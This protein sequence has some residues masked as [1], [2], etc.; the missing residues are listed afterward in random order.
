MEHEV[1]SRSNYPWILKLS[2]ACLLPMLLQLTEANAYAGDSYRDFLVDHGYLKDYEL[3]RQDNQVYECYQVVSNEMKP[4]DMQALR[5]ISIA[6]D[7]KVVS[8]GEDLTYIAW[9]NGTRAYLT[10]VDKAGHTLWGP[11]AADTA[12]ATQENLQLIFR[13][14][15]GVILSWTESAYDCDEQKS[16]L[17]RFKAQKFDSGG[18]RLWGKHGLTIHE[19]PWRYR[20]ELLPS[21][22]DGATGVWFGW[23]HP[24]QYVY[25]QRIDGDGKKLWSDQEKKIKINAPEGFKFVKVVPTADGGLM[26]SNG[27]DFT[28]VD[29]KHPAGLP[30]SGD[31]K[32]QWTPKTTSYSHFDPYLLKSDAADITL[33][34]RRD[35]RYP[36]DRHLTLLRLDKNGLVEWK[37]ILDD[38]VGESNYD[39]SRGRIRGFV[40]DG[41]GGVIAVWIK[42]GAKDSLILAQHV[43]KGGKV[44]WEKPVILGSARIGE[45]MD[46]APDSSGGA[47]VTWITYDMARGRQWPEKAAIIFQDVRI[48]QVDSQGKLTW[49][50]PAFVAGNIGKTGIGNTPTIASDGD[51]GAIVT[52]IDGRAGFD[53]APMQEEDKFEESDIPDPQITGLVYAQ[54][55]A[56]SGEMLWQDDGIDVGGPQA[57]PKTCLERTSDLPIVGALAVNLRTTPSLAS[58]VLKPL[59]R[60]TELIVLERSDR[61]ESVNGRLGRWVRI[62]TS[63]DMEGWVFDAYLVYPQHAEPFPIWP[64]VP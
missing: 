21:G 30:V 7:P 57:S 33:Y 19:S 35:A 1:K 18:N 25:M 22:T 2:V 51:H 13:G 48:Q 37:T 46:M 55:V 36:S 12:I 62:Q 31:G 47:F 40:P 26:I 14:A 50:K 24:F 56:A 52:W 34:G 43:N 64:M 15:D 32:P 23:E 44:L 6:S 9:N 58:E 41:A 20:Y 8:A 60:S 61:C 59:Y 11:L 17:F 45:Q 54:R 16:R 3:V 63:D 5:D 49:N 29:K 42:D 53:I 28:T 39:Y 27:G 10:A 38:D 4:E